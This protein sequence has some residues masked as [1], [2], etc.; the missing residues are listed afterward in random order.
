M[1]QMLIA[2][3]AVLL[4]AACTPAE[5]GAVLGGASGAVVGGAITGDVTGAAVGGAVG[6]AAGAV[7]G[8]ATD[9]GQCIY[10]DRFGR[11]Y[12]AACP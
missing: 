7:I 1:K 9:P 4:A 3:F 2:F 5:R 6:A 12:T 8:R 10:E 11:R